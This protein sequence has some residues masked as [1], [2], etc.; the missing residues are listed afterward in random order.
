ME[1]LT[2]QNNYPLREWHFEHMQK[3][4]VKYVTGISENT[5]TKLPE[6]ITQAI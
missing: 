6:K 1:Y 5:T 4:I 2:A 3:T